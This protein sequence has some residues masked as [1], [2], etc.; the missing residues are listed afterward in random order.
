VNVTDQLKKNFPNL[1]IETAVEY[2]TDAGELVQLIVERWVSRTP[3]TQHSPRRCAP[4]LS[5]WKSLPGGR[6]I[7]WHLGC[8]HSSTAG[9]CQ[10]DRGVTWPKQ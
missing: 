9:H 7:R 10:H 4:T 5:W 2:S 8:N 6:K 3:L 1:R